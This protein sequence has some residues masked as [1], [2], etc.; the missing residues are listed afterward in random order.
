[1][2][3]DPDL[4]DRI[5]ELLGEQAGLTERKMFGGLGFMLDGHMTAAAS[6]QG[7][8][9]LR[10]DPA[11]TPALTAQPGVARFEMGGRAMEGWL[12]VDADTVADEARLRAWLTHGIAYVRSL[13]PK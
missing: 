8:L 12:H 11:D 9:L 4:A 7:G 6:S 13:P 5:R 2:A 3:Y 1:M 10:V